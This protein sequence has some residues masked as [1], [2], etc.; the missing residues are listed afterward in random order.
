[1]IAGEYYPEGTIFGVPKQEIGCIGTEYPGGSELSEAFVPSLLIG[2]GG[3][4]RSE[5]GDDPALYD[6]WQDAVRDMT[7]GRLLGRVW[8]KVTTILD[9]EGEIPTTTC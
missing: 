3:L 9:G 2:C 8:E 6:H 5:D 4:Y 1:M 7:Y